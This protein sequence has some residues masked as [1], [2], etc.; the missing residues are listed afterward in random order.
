MTTNKE[1]N[2]N[3]ADTLKEGTLNHA[4]SFCK[5]QWQRFR[6]D[7]SEAALVAAAEAVHFKSD[8]RFFANFDFT[9]EG[10]KRFKE[11]F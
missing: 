9:S 7:L 11:H 1:R 10:K 3:R 4:L 2:S 6:Y 5:S 8:I